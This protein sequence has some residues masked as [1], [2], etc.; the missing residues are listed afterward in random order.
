MRSSDLC[1]VLRVRESP[2]V[3]H[4]TSQVEYWVGMDPQPSQDGV[5]AR[6]KKSSRLHVL[7]NCV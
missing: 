2:L 6:A 1:F 4:V 5:T 3:E 7:L